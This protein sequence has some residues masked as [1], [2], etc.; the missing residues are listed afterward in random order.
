ME[1]VPPKLQIW[2]NKG[3]D[4]NTGVGKAKALPAV[5]CRQDCAMVTLQFE[6]NS[7][8]VSKW[9]GAWG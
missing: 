5:E 3:R 1:S 8:E 6:C 2:S 4:P 9:V 7:N